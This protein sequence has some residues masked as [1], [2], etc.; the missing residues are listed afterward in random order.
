MARFNPV[1]VSGRR[2]RKARRTTFKRIKKVKLSVAGDIREV[3][4]RA[5]Q[6]LGIRGNIMDPFN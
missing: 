5:R 6:R 3:K 2:L 1:G 4:S